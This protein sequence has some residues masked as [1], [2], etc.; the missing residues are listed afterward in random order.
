MVQIKLK[1]ISE[2][3]WEIPKEPPMRV[4]ARIYAS[5]K[6]LEKM[7]EDRTI[8]Q[9]KNVST[10]P[11][12]Q[13]HMIVMPDGHEGY[14]FPI[15]G[16]AAFDLNEGIITPG[17][18]GFDINCGVR[19]LRTNLTFDEIKD[20]IKE[21]INEIFKNVPAGLGETGKIHLTFSEL[22][23][24]L[25]EGAKWAVDHGYGWEEDL[26]RIESYGQLED[27]D[28][29]VVSNI[30][31]RRGAP[32][33]GT[34]GS[35]NHFLEIQ[36]VD[37][38]YDEKVAK[39]LGIETE[40]QITV[41]IHTGSRGFGHQVAQDYI[42]EFERSFRDILRKLPDRELI[43]APWGSKQ[44]ERYWKA[45]CCAANY[46]WC[47]RQLITHWV[48]ESFEKVFRTSSDQ[49]GL[50]L[51]Y[52]V[53]HN[54]AKIEEHEID[55]KKKKVIVHR[56]G[57]TRAFPPGHPELI[58]KY[59]KIGQPILIPGSMGTAS[60]I[61]IGT[62]KAMKISF[63]STAHGAGRT[64]SRAK[65]VKSFRYNQVVS[66]LSSMGIYV[67][68]ATRK[69]LVEE[70]PEAYKDIDEVAKVSHN[71]GIGKLVVRL[72]PIGVIKG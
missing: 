40:G 32:Q 61:L 15:G 64:M 62:E 26:G 29:D 47:N 43:Y 58:D 49:L 33:L 2:F 24:V 54:I 44:A 11:G 38:I 50:E 22:D 48:R 70:V 25:K 16:V 55:G 5:E 51:I 30:A 3:I 53:A 67:K 23:K 6:L 14:G 35:G 66:K 20:K 31:K 9:A 42:R 12:I 19:V 4:P 1:K 13:K 71:L 69:G 57:A 60:Y 63:G 18:I 10:L 8:E 21:L 59:K 34:L 37:R 46:A 39:E 7:K 65:A 36:V 45:M 68:S 17:G 56:K 27:A 28:P 52:D 41:M 72:K